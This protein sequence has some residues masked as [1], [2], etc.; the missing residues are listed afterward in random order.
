MDT[1]AL[2]QRLVRTNSV[3][4]ALMENG[5]GEPGVVAIL[6]EVLAELPVTVK[7]LEGMAGRPTL[8]AVLKGTGTGP[9]LLFN[10]H[11]DTVGVENM[12]DPF[13]GRIENGRLYG[14]GSYDMKGGLAAAVCALADLAEGPPLAG[15][16]VLAAVADEEF[17]SLGTQE[18]LVYYRT[19]GAVV[20]EPTALDLCVAHKGF[21]WFQFEIEGRAAH[22]SR[23]DLGIDANLA[24]LPV[25]QG[26]AELNRELSRRPPHALLGRASLHVASMLGGNAW[27][28]YAAH[29]TLR[30]E[31]RLL[32]HETIEQAQE[33]MNRIAPAKLILSRRGFETSSMSR[34]SSI[35]MDVLTDVRGTAPSITGQ[36]PWF[37]AA[38][39]AAAGIET[40]IVGHDGAGAHAAEEFA[41]LDSVDKLRRALVQIANRWCNRN[42]PAA[43]S[44]AQ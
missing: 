3:N 30:V 33:E 9:S 31:R 36:S 21:A 16:V 14:R 22:G 43:R 28:T 42:S 18:F 37:D 8:V 4:P 39:L 27:S 13:D 15:D 32:P 38:L 12:K 40:I 11:T 26:L 5:P 7:R 44:S 25:L 35:A 19:D 17:A 41:D 2:L 24:A 20:T 23:P 29:C 10:A 34:L 6:E 1:A